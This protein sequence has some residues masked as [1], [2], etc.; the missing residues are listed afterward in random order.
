MRDGGFSNSHHLQAENTLLKAQIAGV[1][2]A[3]RIEKKQKKLKK[4]LFTELRGN[5]GN[6]AT[7]ED[8]GCRQAS[9]TKG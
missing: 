4:G 9:S 6:T 5:D 7:S 3:V 1:Q 2:G 8:F